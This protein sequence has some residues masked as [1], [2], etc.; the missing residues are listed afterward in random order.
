MST[1]AYMSIKTETG[2]DITK[3]PMDSYEPHIIEKTIVNY[4][5]LNPGSYP[6]QV[7]DRFHIVNPNMTPTPFQVLTPAQ[8]QAGTKTPAWVWAPVCN[9]KT[10][11]GCPWGYFEDHGKANKDKGKGKSK[12]WCTDFH[13]SG[14]CPRGDKC[15]YIH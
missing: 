7:Y 6:V 8:T 5:N 1:T 11:C 4:C 13:N 9:C 10:Q 15:R 12:S 3:F 2:Q 14:K